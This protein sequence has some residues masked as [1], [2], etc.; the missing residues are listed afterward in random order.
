MPGICSESLSNHITLQ[1]EH[2]PSKRIFKAF[3]HVMP[4]LVGKKHNR[5]MREQTL[6]L[7][8][9]LSS[10]TQLKHFLHQQGL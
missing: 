4:L 3:I 7:P 6:A 2:V 10:L 8:S 5:R 1:W 9:I